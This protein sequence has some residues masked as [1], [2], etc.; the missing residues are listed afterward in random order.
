MLSDTGLFRTFPG[1]QIEKEKGED[2]NTLLHAV[3]LDMSNFSG[4]LKDCGKYVRS[5]FEPC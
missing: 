3:V 2:N 5:G 4:E 1:S